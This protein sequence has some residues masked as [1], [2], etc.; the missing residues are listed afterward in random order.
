MEVFNKLGVDIGFVT[1][2]LIGVNFILLVLCIILFVKTSGIKKRYKKFMSGSD[3]HSLEDEINK[4]FIQ[5]EAIH[6]ANEA[7]TEKLLQL[8]KLVLAS[9]KKVGIV[10]YDAFSEMGG[11]LSF[12]LTLLDSNN[13]GV[14][15]N[16]MH[17]S[18]EGC[19]TYVKEIVKGESFIVLSEEEKESL[20]QA[21]SYKM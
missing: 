17:S 14:L 9:Y 13:N 10:K 4:K 5:L 11:K 20:R 19:Y 1:L 21:I 6:R 2:G 3:G 16:S 12:V 15:L 8:E 7:N 18:R